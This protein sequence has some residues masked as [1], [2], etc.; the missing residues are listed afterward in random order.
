MQLPL[1]ASDCLQQTIRDCVSGDLIE[2]SKDTSYECMY[3]QTGM[4]DPHSRIYTHPARPLNIVTAVARFVWLVAG[5]NRVEDIAYYEPKVVGFS[6][7]GLT[8]PGSDYGMRLFQPR[9]GLNQIQGVVD[10]LNVDPG[11]RQA[12]AVVWQPEDAVRKSKDIPCTFGLFFH[13][14]KNHLDMCV[15]MRS[16][17]AFRILP[18]NLFEFSMLQELVAAQ[19][20]S[21]GKHI[22]LGTYH[23]WAASMHVYKNEHEWQ[24]TLEIA[25]GTTLSNTSPHY[26]TMPPMPLNLG[27]WNPMTM[28][29]LLSQLEARLRHVCTESDME[30]L[31]DEARELD[32]YWQTLFF[33]L[34]AWTAAKHS[35]TEMFDW[36]AEVPAELHDLLE[37]A[38]EKVV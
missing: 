27:R 13:V 30:F 36:T 26:L 34:A 23:H 35:W 32:E 12:A 37:H 3:Y 10:R 22:E 28:A 5:N 33:I 2:G 4:L 7:D 24:P 25:S 21:Q 20:Q 18:F 14:R 19:L 31:I 17:N 11:S 16:N 29:R 9:P 8:V 38:L 15:N 1:T 6:D